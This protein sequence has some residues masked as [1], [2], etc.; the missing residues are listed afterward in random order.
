MRN[1]I[2][3]MACIIRRG[4]MLLAWALVP[5]S[6]F[7]QP[8]GISPDFE[9][10]ALAALTAEAERLYRGDEAMDASIERV[11]G[12]RISPAHVEVA[13]ERLRRVVLNVDFHRYLL[14]LMVP[15][16][17]AETT[18]AQMRS[19]ALEGMATLQAKGLL[20]MPAARQEDFVHHMLEMLRVLPP[21]VCKGLYLSTVSTADSNLLER[22]Y[23]ASLPLARF[24]QIVT[25]Y[26]DAVLAELAR[27]PS[28]RSL[29]REQA[30]LADQAH[31][32]AMQRRFRS[33][34]AP[35][36]LARLLRDREGAPARDACT[37]LT[38]TFE[39][40]ADLP[41]PYRAW[42]ILQFVSELQ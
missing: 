32:L 33:A 27:T 22:A 42:R 24:D 3:T 14:Q 1:S 36:A 34:F 18:P 41:E 15:I 21:E 38:L 26:S 5:L 8:E 25:L 20:R 30:A 16:A 11:Y 12:T 31:K 19:A 6:A 35:D 4:V 28:A 10:R 37:L 39:T 40:M 17:S 7:A 13:R 23:I 29:S 2:A 9:A